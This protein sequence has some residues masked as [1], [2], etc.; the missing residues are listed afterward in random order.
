MS[1][2]YA[3]ELTTLYGVLETGW[4]RRRP[5]FP[6]AKP[7]GKPLNTDT[8]CKVNGKAKPYLRF[9]RKGLD[10]APIEIGNPGSNFHAF[11]SIAIIDVYV[12]E[13]D[14]APLAA[15]F[16][17]EILADFAAYFSTPRALLLRAIGYTD[18]GKVSTGLWYQGSIT[19]RCE[20]HMR[21]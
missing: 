6:I 14:G 21:Q 9:S 20:R 19:I 15:V 13:E 18:V 17:D 2:G 16:G 11:H 5:T 1:A 10:G 8:D 12:P 4:G 3:A 7:W